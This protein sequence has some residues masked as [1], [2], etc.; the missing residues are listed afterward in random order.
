[1]KNGICLTAIHQ[2]Q[3]TKHKI[4]KVSKK[5]IHQLQLMN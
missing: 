5:Q 4:L 2:L 1:M 3:L